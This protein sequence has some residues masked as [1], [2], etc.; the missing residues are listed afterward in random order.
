MLTGVVYAMAAAQLMKMISVSSAHQ[1]CQNRVESRG[2][3]SRFVILS[4]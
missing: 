4:K 1:G 3:A 2:S